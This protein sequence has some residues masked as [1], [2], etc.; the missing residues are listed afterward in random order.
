MMEQGLEEKYSINK[1]KC[2]FDQE[3]DNLK[4]F[5]TY[6]QDNCL[7][8]CK[9]ELSTAAC[10][11]TPWYIATNGTKPICD[12]FGNKCFEHMSLKTNDELDFSRPDN[13]PCGCFPACR[14][15]KYIPEVQD[16]ENKLKGKKTCT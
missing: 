1:R 11:C 16:T 14:S 6:S 9:L 7:F 4:L 13:P 3:V 10:G 12:L 15:I 8:E 2:R 5:D